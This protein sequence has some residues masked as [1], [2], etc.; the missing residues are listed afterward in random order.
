[1]TSL[2]ST[3]YPLLVLITVLVSFD[4]YGRVIARTLAPELSGSVGLTV[5]FGFAIFLT[6]SGC[7][8]LL[9]MGSRSLL[10]GYLLF[11]LL[12]WAAT[13]G[14]NSSLYVFQKLKIGPIS[15]SK[16]AVFVAV[17]IYI[18]LYAAN[19]LYLPFNVHDDYDAYFVFAKRIL[20]EG[21]QGADFF[22][23]RGIEQGFG[24]GNYL[25]ALFL[26]FVPL[27]HIRVAEAGTGVILLFLLVLDHIRLRES[28]FW[29]ILGVATITFLVASRA[30]LANI[31]PILSGCALAYGILL[32]SCKPNVNYAPVRSAL[33]GLLLASLILLKGN[34]LVAAAV[35][36]ATYY[37]T[38][39]IYV[40]RLWIFFE[41][42]I[43]LI[44][45][46]AC[47]L[48]WMFS[49]L[50]FSETA[51][52]PILGQGVVRS[53]SIG[54]VNQ[55]TFIGAIYGFRWLYMLMLIAGLATFY[56]HRDRYL[57]IFSAILMLLSVTATALLAL[58]PAGTLRYA[59]I[60]LVI[61]VAFL[62]VSLIGMFKGRIKPRLNSLLL[63]YSSV[64]IT[65]LVTVIA[66]NIYHK[67]E[68]ED[69]EY[70]SVFSGQKSKL[71]T[72]ALQ[73]FD[74]DSPHYQRQL[75]RIQ[76]LQAS[77]PEHAV[78]LLR[79]DMPFFFDFSRNRIYVMDW[80][81]S[82]GPSP[83]TP[84]LG[85][86]EE[87]AHYLRINKIRYVVYSYRNEALHSRKDF[88]DRLQ[89]PSAWIRNL[90]VRTFAVQDQLTQLAMSYKVLYDNGN[91]FVLDLCEKKVSDT[92][93]VCLSV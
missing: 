93:V 92:Q 8:E 89:H 37:L 47:L 24:A 38:R 41:C 20:E 75:T 5:T 74:T 56:F 86:P 84:Y 34:F 39:L 76:K 9:H 40:R 12:L 28:S 16:T 2:V 6:L 36:A 52:Y 85:E 30:H 70:L 13:G 68:D 53:G 31:S 60:T 21:Y 23:V 57:H 59:Y 17:L 18:S 11:G 81:G 62:G 69:G 43:T 63:K 71:N 33:L 82:A 73:D 49:N 44:I 29:E 90:A 15:I 26:V 54:I 67:I 4:G 14:V 58:T 48:P 77:I 91:D 42:L 88:L 78:I 64:L 65:V 72:S 87:F 51:F 45:M 10:A 80:P 50:S 66:V 19:R 79:V 35:M 83:G 7:V 61:P 27:Q 25:N 55:E 46:V 1:M 22:N 3:I 32:F